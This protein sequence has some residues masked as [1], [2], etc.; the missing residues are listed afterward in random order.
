MNGRNILKY[1]IY[2]IL[3]SKWLITYTLVLLG[4]S[5]GLIYFSRDET[6]SLVSVLNI[7]LII[8]PL[9][10]II[11]GSVHYYNSKEFIQMLLTQ[12][13]RRITIFKAEFMGLSISLSAGFLIG[14]MLPLS[15]IGISKA[16]FLLMYSGVFLSFIFSSLAFLISIMIDDKVKGIGLLLFI[17]LFFSVLFDG[18]ILII[19]YAFSSYP[20]E[21]FT[22]FMT[23]LNPVDISR[24]MILL[25]VDLSAMLG[26]TGATFLK[27]FGSFN[28]MFI[29]ILTLILWTIIPIILAG[30]RFKKKNF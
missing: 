13:V 4:V 2:D 23:L 15:F 26:F 28:G 30:W 25:N 18:L 1:I 5:S 14:I 22:V 9:V 17:W 21:K 8:V 27:F 11:F 6:K 16:F 24:I 20:M 29:T 19:Y 10:S 7:V 12:P 3:R